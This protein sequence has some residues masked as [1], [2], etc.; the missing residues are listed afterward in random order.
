MTLSNSAK[1]PGQ[2]WVRISGNASGS[3]RAT[4]HEVDVEA[5]DG[6][7]ELLEPVETPLLRPPVELVAPVLDE[8][9]QVGLVHPELPPDALGLVG[10]AGARQTLAQVRQHTVGDLDGER[11]DG[12]A[13]GGLARGRGGR[14]RPGGGSGDTGAQRQC[15]RDGQSG[16][17]SSHGCASFRGASGPDS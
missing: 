11:L 8:L 14:S 5:V 7:L 12:R 13:G 2:P 4:V 1:V 16:G 9:T 15:Q 17:C 10:H 3:G 6:G